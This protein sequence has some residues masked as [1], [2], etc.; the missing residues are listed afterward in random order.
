MRRL[1]CPIGWILAGIVL[2]G[3]GVPARA[4]LPLPTTPEDFHVP[5]TQVGDVPPWVASAAVDC[6]LCHGDY[7]T[8]NEP[9]ASWRGSLMGQAARDPLFYAQMSAANQDVSGVGSFCMRC[10]APIT[11]VRSEEDTSELQSLTNL[12]CRLLLEIGR[13]SCRERV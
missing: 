10:H 6:A 5:G 4:Q 11:L 2:I 3:P 1:L 7:D 8:D 9:Y 13:A 12:V